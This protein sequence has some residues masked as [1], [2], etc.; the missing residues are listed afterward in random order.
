LTFCHLCYM[1]YIFSSRLRTCLWQRNAYLQDG[2]RNN[3]VVLKHLN[4]S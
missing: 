4:Q 2:F 3:I 1:N